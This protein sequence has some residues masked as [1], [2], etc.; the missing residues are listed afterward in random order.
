MRKQ[1][2]YFGIAISAMLLMG[3]GNAFAQQPAT[4]SGCVTVIAGDTIWGFDPHYNLKNLADQNPDIHPRLDDSSRL[5][6]WHG[7]HDGRVDV[8]IGTCIYGVTRQGSKLI[9]T[10]PSTPKAAVAPINVSTN[11]T[12]NPQPASNVVQAVVGGSLLLILLAIAAIALAVWLLKRR[13]P[14]GSLERRFV[15]GGVQPEQARAHAN[16]LASQVHP[17]RPFVIL[18]QTR[19]RAIGAVTSEYINPARQETVVLDGGP[20]SY[21]YRTRLRFTDV[22]PNEETEMPFLAPCGNPIRYGWIGRYVPGLN[23]Q[24]LGE[25]EVVPE[26]TLAPVAVEPVAEATPA[27]EA[28]PAVVEQKTAIVMTGIELP[29]EGDNPSFKMTRLTDGTVV[30]E[31][32]ASSGAQFMLTVPAASIHYAAG[33]FSFDA[34]GLPV[35]LAVPVPAEIIA[36]AAVRQ[37]TAPVESEVMQEPKAPAVPSKPAE[38][39]AMTKQLPVAQSKPTV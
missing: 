34:S 20:N 31:L 16:T 35:G 28:V 8:A 33:K 14:A 25:P 2:V 11:P 5:S 37:L 9:P 6:D 24:Y 4:T 15:P 29:V 30:L 13:S 22:T 27:P 3:L 7:V 32:A 38:D 18:S 1:N 23:F 10:P 39:E 36:A 21:V 17:G 19:Q 26:P 12:S